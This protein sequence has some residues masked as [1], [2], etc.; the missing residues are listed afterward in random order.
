MKERKHAREKAFQVLYQIDI[1]KDVTSEHLIQSID[2]NVNPYA[3][4]L[5][6]GVLNYR[7]ELDQAIDQKLEKWSFSR[8]G[9]VEKTVLRIA[10]Y[11]LLY[12]QQIPEKVAI[13]EAVELAK[14]FNEDQSGKF[15]NGVLSKFM[16]E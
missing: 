1:N 8:I 14:R 6:Q 15:I 3:K 5:I 7:N 9:T 4:T 11:E 10:V 12:E 13:N 16:N 2:E